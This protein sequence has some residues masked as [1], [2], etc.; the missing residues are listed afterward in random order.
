MKTLLH[1]LTL[2]VALFTSGIVTAQTIDYDT[3]FT[4][5]RMR[6]DLIFAGDCDQ[7]EVF[8]SGLK[9]EFAWSGPKKEL[10]DP[11]RYGEYYLEVI[12]G[13]KVIFSRGFC[14]LF[15]EWR[16]T[17][18]AKR[19]KKAF[20]LSQTIPF[21]KSTIKVSIYERSK[22]SGLF[23]IM[24]TFTIDPNHKSVNCEKENNFEV[25]TIHHSG[26]PAEKVDLLFIAEGYTAEQMDK[27]IEDVNR[28]TK[29]LFE[30]EP[31]AQRKDDFNVRAVKSISED[32][33]TDIPH[34][35][36]WR[37]TVVG[38][39]F[40]T[41]DIDRYL[42]AP[43]QTRISSIASNAHY[44]ALYVI[45]NTDKYGGGGIYNFY[46]LS[47]SGGRSVSEVFVHEF[48]HSFAGLA[49]EYYSSEVAYEDY[50]NLTL[51]PWEP[52]I[53]T[54]VDFNKKWRDLLG[55]QIP[56]PTP[57]K[58]EYKDV[59]GV[60]EGG[61]YMTKGIYRPAVNCR[62]KSNNAPGFCEACQRAISQMID[63]YTK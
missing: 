39:T 34:Q 15:Q 5:E 19:T 13:E 56:I 38:S 24:N 12:S 61:G 37:N 50:Y 28:F 8:L 16:T 4:P 3:Y 46:G 45:V 47:M 20:T 49:D 40:Y 2:I 52:N 17:E 25:A 33:G 1:S 51:E 60:F 58:A 10:L 63:Y 21:P 11:F 18:E 29:A 54:L 9:K 44:D 6:I 48:G 30:T 42:T 36:I 43:D 31:Y 35:D 55:A 57:D 22:K 23:E 7:Q 41:F 32:S 14:S 27:F 26:D 62:M 59:L 53:T